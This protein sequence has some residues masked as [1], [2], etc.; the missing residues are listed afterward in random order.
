[1]LELQGRKK[2]LRDILEAAARE[3]VWR[4]TADDCA[5][6][7]LT[8]RVPRGIPDFP[9]SPADPLDQSCPV[10]HRAPATKPCPHRP[11]PSPPSP[12]GPPGRPGQPGQLS[13]PGQAPKKRGASAP[14]HE[15]PQVPRIASSARLTLAP[16]ASFAPITAPTLAL[17]E[18]STASLPREPV[19]PSL[20][21]LPALLPPRLPFNRIAN[22][23]W[24]GPTTR[25]SV[26]AGRPSMPGQLLPPTPRNG[27]HWPSAD[28]AP[29]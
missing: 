8:P 15:Y 27:I 1:M 20:P 16:P 7:Q 3:R 11:A 19:D 4:R 17:E 25:V 9:P 28:R 22:A 23:A 21:W 29:P 14:G 6:Y 2:Q 12:P 24:K 10:A 5:C 26:P 13:H 18:A